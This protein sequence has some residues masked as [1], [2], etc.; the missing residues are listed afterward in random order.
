[1][2]T[3]RHFWSPL[4]SGAHS[5]IHCCYHNQIYFIL[6]KTVHNFQI[7]Y[8]DLVLD[9]SCTEKILVKIGHFCK[10]HVFSRFFKKWSVARDLIWKEVEI[11]AF[12]HVLKPSQLRKKQF[13]LSDTYIFSESAPE[14]A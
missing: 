6:A 13:K 2:P 10:N 11:F 12:C 9:Y 3:R 5:C 7:I 4:F 1:M 8:Q 14:H